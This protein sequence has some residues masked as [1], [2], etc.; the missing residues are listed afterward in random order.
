MLVLKCVGVSCVVGS[1]RE[2]A[3]KSKAKYTYCE[4]GRVRGL[5]VCR[6]CCESA[7][8]MTRQ[9][10][11]V[12]KK[13]KRLPVN[14]KVSC[15]H[16]VERRRRKICRGSWIQCGHGTN[17]VNCRECDGRRSVPGML[18]GDP[19]AVLGA[20]QGMQGRDQGAR[21]RLE[22]ARSQRAGLGV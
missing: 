12:Q 5:V 1:G 17:K 10:V 9:C 2:A 13:A 15:E 18:R 8:K 21:G 14:A 19:A 20:V 6:Q 3:A 11:E 22:G 4:H 7:L 16:S